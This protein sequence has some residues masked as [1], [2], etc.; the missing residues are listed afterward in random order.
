[1]CTEGISKGPTIAPA[2][3]PTL[4]RE[5]NCFLLR[6]GGFAIGGRWRFVKDGT[7]ASFPKQTTYSVVRNQEQSLDHR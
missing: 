7:I 2:S 1:M 3:V 6:D 4:V 5:T